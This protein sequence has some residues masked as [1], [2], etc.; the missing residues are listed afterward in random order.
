MPVLHRYLSFIRYAFA[1]LMQI[2]FEDREFDIS[3]C[4]PSDY[5]PATGAELLGYGNFDIISG[6]RISQPHPTPHLPHSPCAVLRCAYA[7]T[8]ADGCLGCPML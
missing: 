3:A 2:E 7:A 1:G 6:S 5:C 4:H 8:G